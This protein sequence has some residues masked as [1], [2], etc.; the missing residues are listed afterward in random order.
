MQTSPQITTARLAQTLAVSLG[1][2]AWSA[3]TLAIVLRRRLPAAHQKYADA[4]GASLA[5][6]C[7]A[8]YAPSVPQ[9]AKVLRGMTE[10]RRL[11]RY[12]QRHNLWPDPDL[13]PPQMAP[14]TAFQNLNLPQLAS[15]D[16]L[17]EWL[18]LPLEKLSY[19]AD[20]SSRHEEHGDMPVNHYHYHLHKKRR[21]G[22]RLIE[23]PKPA[24]KAMQRQLLNQII[25]H[26]PLHPDAF[27][28]VRGK[29]C[30]HAAARHAGEAMVVRFDI[31]NFFPSIN[32]GRV[33]G[34]FRSLGYPHPVAT[35]LT[36]LCT[37]R[38]PTWM[39][40]RLNPPDRGIYHQSHLPQGAPTSPALAN[41]IAFSLDV[42]LA[43]LA[44]SVGAQYSRYADDLSFSGDRHV[45]RV[46]L[47]MVPKILR[48]A[49]FA[50]NVRKTRLMSASGRQVITGVVVNQHLNTTRAD[51][52]MLKAVIHACG[53]A[54]DVRWHDAA[55]RGRLL[56]QIAWVE[57]VNPAR[58]T[59][60]RKRLA[61]AI[62]RRNAHVRQT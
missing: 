1:S 27:G 53:K 16:V 8:V 26:V 35:H 12:C 51:Y 3:E 22:K 17:A 56:G 11:Y 57:Q 37:T 19:F 38:T 31:Q 29:N 59:A 24:L 15:L 61:R 45:A 42:R 40:E 32:A 2:G 14:I 10:F 4:F 21:G 54:D 28:F 33:F 20:P 41:L 6:Q 39:S 52:D 43:A 7:P 30:L 48:D 13:S 49:G 36:G 55:F 44:R 9:I 47:H 60:L 25:N 62:Q 34:L 46:L 58:G 18:S 23:A 5:A 50:V